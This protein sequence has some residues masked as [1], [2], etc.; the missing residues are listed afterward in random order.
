MAN[1]VDSVHTQKIVRSVMHMAESLDLQSI[2]EGIETPEQL[3]DRRGAPRLRAGAGLPVLPAGPA[4]ADQRHVRDP[5]RRPG[6][7][8]AGRRLAAAGVAPSGAQPAGGSPGA[9]G[10]GA[11]RRGPLR[12]RSPRRRSR[13]RGSAPGV[14]PGV[15]DGGGEQPQRGVQ[16]RDG[17]RRPRWRRRTPTRRARTGRSGTPAS[18]PRACARS[19]GRSGRRRRKT[20]L[21]P[22]LTTAEVTPRA[23]RPT[24]AARRGRAPSTLIPAA[25]PNQIT[26]R[27]AA[28]ETRARPW[29]RVGVGVACTAA[30][31]ARS[32]TMSSRP[33]RS[34]PSHDGFIGA[35]PVPRAGAVP[36]SSGGPGG[37][38]PPDGPAGTRTRSA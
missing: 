3:A 2:A 8:V 30:Y 25:T 34:S 1:V 9:A 10:R 20:G 23:V 32:R 28:R 13:P 18:G 33:T 5:V 16:L 26:E 12:R 11:G 21:T 35:L 6:R 29:S 31:T 4:R 17:W 27:L 14:H 24:R 7:G 38:A 37:P 36:P 19:P 15:G 22:T